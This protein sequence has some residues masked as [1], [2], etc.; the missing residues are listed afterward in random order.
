MSVR[1]LLPL[2]LIALSAVAQEPHQPAAPVAP[3]AS[4]ENREFKIENPPADP[5]V[6]AR[7]YQIH[8]ALCHG[9]RGE[10]GKGPTL[11][12]PVLPRASD[13]AALLRLLASGI[14]GTEMPGSQLPPAALAQIGAHVRALGRLPPERL[15]GDPARGAQLYVNKG[16]CASCHAVQGRGSAFGP[17]LT[18][19]GARRNAAYLRRALT[20]PAAEVPQSSTP[21]RSDVSMPENFLFVR[22]VTR[23]GRTL[24]GVRLNEDAFSLQLREAS[25]R[26]H[27]FFK[28]DLAELHKDRAFSPM[29]DYTP[30]FSTAELDDLVAYLAS[31][32]G[33]K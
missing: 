1:P 31:L 32:R 28:S 4:I 18:T 23:D 21:Y 10:G 3:A 22:V 5:A 16:A 27:S 20:S 33:Q 2:L 29:P 7:L 12:Q 15:P 30:V 25:G 9:P 13:D 14:A 8:C 17:D 24:A 11:A 26:V 6:G 19:I